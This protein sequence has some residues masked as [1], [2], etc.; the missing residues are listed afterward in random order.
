MGLNGKFNALST[1]AAAKGEYIAQ[2]DGDDYLITNDK[3]QKQVEM[4]DA[5]PHYSA[6]F[7]NARVIF[8]D[9]A[10]PPYLVNYT[11]QERVYGG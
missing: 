10:A 8:D 1:F 11:D 9:N 5:N 3:L 6:C 2:F 4:M 7:H